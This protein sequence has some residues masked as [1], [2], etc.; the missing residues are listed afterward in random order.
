[1]NRI[2]TKNEFLTI[3]RFPSEWEALGMYPDELFSGQQAIYKPG[4]EK[5]SEHDRNGAFH[6]WLRKPPDKTELMNLVRLAALDPDPLLG[7]SVRQYIY[8]SNNFDDD[9]AELDKMLFKGIAPFD[10]T[11]E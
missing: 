1:M 2:M 11:K 5:G 9:V 6:W 8:H 10:W 7:N 3:M 4:D